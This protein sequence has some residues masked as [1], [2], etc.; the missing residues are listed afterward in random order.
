MTHSLRITA[1]RAAL[2]AFWLVVSG[3]ASAGSAGRSIEPPFE[4][5]V[6][7]EFATPGTSLTLTELD[8][9]PMGD[10]VRTVRISY[11]VRATGFASG[12]PVRL[13]TKRGAEFSWFG[14]TVNANGV[15]G[16]AAGME[17]LYKI[18]NFV[19][20]EPLALALASPTGDKLAQAK[21]FPFPIEAHGTNGCS[22]LMSLEDTA[23]RMWFVTLRGFEPNQ[24]IEIVGQYS[25]RTR[26]QTQIASDTGEY[27]WFVGFEHPAR[28]VASITATGG[29]RTVSVRYNVGYDAV[30]PKDATQP[31]P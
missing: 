2:C 15:F 31:T 26:T 12:E 11:E 30:N 28:G 22:I 4:W 3:C 18:S 14:G 9:S 5:D 23:G 17:S 29:D 10:T 19:P 16:L 6:T 24:P 27:A 13:W 25:S 20:G 8:R 7:G 1:F 21:A